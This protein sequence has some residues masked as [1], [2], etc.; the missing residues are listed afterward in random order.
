MLLLAILC[1]VT[2]AAL[3]KAY[4][5]WSARH[6]MLEDQLRGQHELFRSTTEE[7]HVLQVQLDTRTREVGILN[8]NLAAAQREIATERANRLVAEDEA[9]RTCEDLTAAREDTRFWKST[10]EHWQSEY[11]KANADAIKARE[12]VADWVAQRT[13][14]RSI[15]NVAPPLPPNPQHMRPVQKQRIQARAAVHLAEQQFAQA[16]A[17]LKK[18]QAAAAAAAANGAPPP[19]AEPARA[20]IT[21]N[22]I[23]E[24]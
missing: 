15:F 21:V 7:E 18:R 8:D 4:R 16:E 6:K 20:P 12:I 17:D 11:E 1:A 23:H 2:M 10:A 13:F 9:R 22:E 19:H 24:A 14:G 5:Y 3:I